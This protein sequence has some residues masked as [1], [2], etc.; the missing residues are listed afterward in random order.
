MIRDLLRALASDDFMIADDD[1]Q[2]AKGAY[3]FPL[4]IKELRD[5]L[6]RRKIL[7]NG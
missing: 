2:F 1:V 4:T 5:E 7:R 3:E 6:K